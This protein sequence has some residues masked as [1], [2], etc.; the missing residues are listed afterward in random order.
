M[1]VIYFDQALV[2]VLRAVT[3]QW[4]FLGSFPLASP[5]LG[6]ERDLRAFD[7]Y[8]LIIQPSTIF[9]PHTFHREG[10]DLFPVEEAGAQPRIADADNRIGML[11]KDVAYLGSGCPYHMPVLP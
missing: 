8:R 6:W 9:L 11:P 2:H 4:L 7:L 3:R 5:R 1:S 10:S